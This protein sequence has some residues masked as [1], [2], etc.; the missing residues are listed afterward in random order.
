MRILFMSALLLANLAFAPPALAEDNAATG[1]IKS[2]ECG[3]N[4]YLTITKDNGEELTALCAA[5]ECAPWNE[6]AAMPDEMIGKAVEV[7]I[8]SGKQYDGA[9]NEM[10][11]FPSFAKVSVVAK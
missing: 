3:D 11:E 2:Y 5:D 9:G 7:T 6:E 4:C 10:G 8:A 1:N